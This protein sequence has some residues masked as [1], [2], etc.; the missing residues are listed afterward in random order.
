MSAPD[1]DMPW[2]FEIPDSLGKLNEALAECGVPQRD[3][4][5][6]EIQTSEGRVSFAKSVSAN[7]QDANNRAHRIL[8]AL[9]AEALQSDVLYPVYLAALRGVPGQL[10]WRIR[11]EVTEYIEPLVA[12]ENGMPIRT[13]SFYARFWIEPIEPQKDTA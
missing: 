8:V 3:Y 1:Q 2:P 4:V 10:I 11:P 6:G 5:P 13:I 12:D 7:D 9:G